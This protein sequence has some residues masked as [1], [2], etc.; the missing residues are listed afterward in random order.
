MKFLWLL[1]LVPV[2]YVVFLFAD[3]PVHKRTINGE[4]I[5]IKSDSIK[6]QTKEGSIESIPKFNLKL[7]QDVEVNI[8]QK[9]LT[10]KL[11]YQYTN[12]LHIEVSTNNE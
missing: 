5:D 6:I 9:R 2:L 1:V 12:T 7:G 3:S 8:M 10:G 4:V 11:L